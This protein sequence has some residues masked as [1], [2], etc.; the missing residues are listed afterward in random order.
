MSQ[1]Y[2]WGT[3]GNQKDPVPGCSVVPVSR[4]LLTDLGLTIGAIVVVSSV[5]LVCQYSWETR[6]LWAGFFMKSCGT[7]LSQGLV[8]F[9]F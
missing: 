5:A 6:S 1:T 2:L 4:G 3:D 7:G 8:F 9:S